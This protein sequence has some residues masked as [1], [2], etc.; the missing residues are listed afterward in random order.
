MRV[1]VREKE[2]IGYDASA[3]LA[4]FKAH[5]DWDPCV[6]TCGTLSSFSPT[7]SYVD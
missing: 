6:L 7:E 4:V 5:C 3:N 2:E 1:T